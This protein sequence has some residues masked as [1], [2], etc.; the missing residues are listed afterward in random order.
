MHLYFIHSLLHFTA[1]LKKSV[2]VETKKWAYL[3]R[4]ITLCNGRSMYQYKVHAKQQL[5][6]LL[7]LKDLVSRNFRVSTFFEL[8]AEV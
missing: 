1:S 7:K 8:A 4:F 5:N 6:V 2:G 3:I